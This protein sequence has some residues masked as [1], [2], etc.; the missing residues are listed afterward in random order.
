MAKADYYDL[1]GVQRN[2]SNDDLKK[3]YRKM[4]IKHHPDKNPGDKA[5]EEKFKEVSEAYEVLSDADKRAAY[6]RFGHA[7]F[8]PGGRGGGGFHDASDI[9]Q[10]VFGSGGGFGGI[11]GDIFGSGSNDSQTGNDLRYDMQITFE[12]AVF[13][14]EKEIAIDRQEMCETCDGSG[15]SPGTSTNRCVACGG[16]GQVSTQRGFFMVSQTCPRCRGAGQIIEKPCKTCSGSGLREK[17]AK[18]KIRIPAGVENGMRLRSSGNGESGARGGP[19]GDLYVV[20]HVKEHEIFRRDGE[21]LYCEVPISYA[22]AALGAKLEVPTLQGSAHVEIPPGTQSNTIFR[23]R[24]KGVKSLNGRGHGDQHVRVIVEVPTKLN[25][26]Q[27]H[28]LEEFAKACNE[29]VLPMHKS[30]LERVKRMFREK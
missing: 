16:R 21:N 15:A 17:E 23:L 11:F 25:K 14:C 4:A 19:A 22:M 24:N 7:A 30:F 2:A 27:R 9:F 1:L 20:L 28:K 5:S 12:E 18:I 10:Q 26:E 8:G 13:G 3:A 6:D 29:D